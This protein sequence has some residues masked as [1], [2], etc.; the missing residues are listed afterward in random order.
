M[1]KEMYLEMCDNMNSEPDEDEVPPDFEDLSEQSQVVLSMF[2]YLPDKW[3]SMAGTYD[4]KDYSNLF[5]IYELFSINNSDWLLYT[6]LLNVVVNEKITSI[7]KKMS[8]GAKK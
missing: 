5:T 7:N 8:K 4:G 2:N 6:D 1:T 3:N